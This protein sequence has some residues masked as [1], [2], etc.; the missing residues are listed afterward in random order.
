MKPTKA[1][2]IRLSPEQAEQLETVAQVDDQ[3]IAAVIRTAI[4][5]HI[6]ARQGDTEFRKSLRDR[7]RRAEKFLKG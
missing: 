3:P 4:E 6:A 7:L 2:T 5:Q 1:M